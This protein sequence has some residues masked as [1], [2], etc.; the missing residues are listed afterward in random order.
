MKPV[1]KGEV[2]SC[3]NGHEMCEALDDIP[4]GELNWHQK[5]GKWR[6]HEIRQGELW[7]MCDICGEPLTIHGYKGQV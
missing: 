7:P 1:K 3:E 5:I 6:Q 4:I 2:F